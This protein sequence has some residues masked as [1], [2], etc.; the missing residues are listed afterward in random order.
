MSLKNRRI[1]ITSGP[2]WVAIDSVRI[3]SNTATGATG[4]LL[5]EALR[6]AGA[7]VTLVLGPRCRLPQNRNIRVVGFTYFDE[8][9]GILKKELRGREYDAVI[10]SAAVSDYAP[11]RKA[12]KKISSNMRSLDLRLIRTPKLIDEIR[13]QAPDALL[14]GFK[15]IP[16]AA[17]G[18]LFAAA[19]KLGKRSRANMVVA[20]TVHNG[21]YRAFV[22]APQGMVPEAGSKEELTDLLVMYLKAFFMKNPRGALKCSCGKH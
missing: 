6:K 9:R 20:N 7:E 4:V 1:L 8:L 2:T 11:A 17:P 19:R 15:F 10:H 5:A 16:E 3:I 13:R 21:T 18:T 12:K 14:V 22:V